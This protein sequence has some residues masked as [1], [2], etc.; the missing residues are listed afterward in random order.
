VPTSH[1]TMCT[2]YVLIHHVFWFWL[3]K[4]TATPWKAAGVRNRFRN[5]RT[6]I[7]YEVLIVG[8]IHRSCQIDLQGDRFQAP[9]HLHWNTCVC[10]YIYIYIYMCIS[11]WEIDTEMDM[12]HQSHCGADLLMMYVLIWY[13]NGH[14]LEKHPLMNVYIVFSIVLSHYA[15]THMDHALMRS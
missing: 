7:R 5:T 8:A 11:I 14:V 1:V 3:R 13:N 6:C 2:S 15:T 4:Y 12:E 10:I 9:M